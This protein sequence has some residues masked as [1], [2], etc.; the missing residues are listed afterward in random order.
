MITELGQELLHLGKKYKNMVV[1]ST[2]P[3]N[4]SGLE[5]FARFFG[6]RYFTFGLGTQNMVSAAVGF[7]LR[8]KLPVL[9]GEGVLE[10]AFIQVKSDLCLPNLNVKIV[11]FALES[12]F[13]GSLPNLQFRNSLE[14]MVAEYGPFVLTYTHDATSN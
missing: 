12:R 9:V 13:Q 14:D 7:V 3:E 5:D 6:D 4:S 10:K 1:L 2:L 11:D 8:G